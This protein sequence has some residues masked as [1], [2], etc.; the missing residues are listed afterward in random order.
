M[1]SA[2]KRVGARVV[3]VLALVLAAGVI[4]VGTANAGLTFSSKFGSGG[5]GAGQFGASDI[6]VSGNVYIGDVGNNRVDVFNAGGGF[7]EAFGWGVADGKLEA[8]ACSS[9]CLT[10]LTGKLEGKSGGETSG[11]VAGGGGEVTVVEGAP[12]FRIS[13][14]AGSKFVKASGWGVQAGGSLLE[15]CTTACFAGANGAGAGEV[16]SGSATSVGGTL[17]ILQDNRIDQFATSGASFNGG[18]GW[19]V[20][21]GANVFET[22]LSKCRAAATGSAAGQLSDP[23]NIAGG[24]AFLFVPDATQ[25]RLNVFTDA[26]TFVKAY[27]WGVAD[28]AARFETCSASCQAGLPGYGAGQFETPYGVA[29]DGSGHVYVGEP[30]GKRIIQI[31][32]LKDEFVAAYGYGVVSN[33]E[34]TFQTCTTATGCVQSNGGP[35]GTPLGEPTGMALQGSTLYVSDGDCKCIASGAIWIDIFSL[36]TTSTPGG[37]SPGGGAP[38]GGGL[39]SGG[40]GAAAPSASDIIHLLASQIVPTGRAAS[41]KRILHAGGTVLTLTALEKGAVTVGWYQVP[42]G[43]HVAAKHKPRPVLVASGTL[44][45]TAPGTGRLRVALTRAGKT[46]FKHSKHLKLTAKGSF[47]APGGAALTTKRL[48]ALGR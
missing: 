44:S 9:V 18:A 7:L 4:S 5:P 12:Y 33:K 30:T 14:F 11:V 21:D 10:G 8:E 23:T 34:P 37:G 2:S 16:S 38:G 25:H 48:F 27:G 46:L 17:Y 47:T 28:G 15:T 43:A 32:Y 6:A 31:D 35:E 3:G 29:A 19:G 41:I 36:S 24:G 1:G 20:A 26:G 39:G 45:F 42:P 22:C 13:V 40:P